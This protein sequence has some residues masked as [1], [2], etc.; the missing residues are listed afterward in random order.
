MR[1]FMVEEHKE[2]TAL[3]QGCFETFSNV[4]VAFV[5]LCVVFSRGLMCEMRVVTLAGRRVWLSGRNRV[6]LQLGRPPDPVAGCWTREAA[7]RESESTQCTLQAALV[8][9][10]A[11]GAAR[12]DEPEP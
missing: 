12:V 8:A 10:A 4:C 3:V 6:G 11:S 1:P 2:Q 7:A 9:A 5:G